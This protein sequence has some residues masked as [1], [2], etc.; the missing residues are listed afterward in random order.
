MYKYYFYPK[1][2][3][4]SLLVW[5]YFPLGLRLSFTLMGRF[6]SFFVFLLTNAV[7]SYI[8]VMIILDQYH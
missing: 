6:G 3:H 7:H 4:N 8:I 2:I 5:F 1:F